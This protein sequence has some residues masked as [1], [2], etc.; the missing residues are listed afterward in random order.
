MMNYRNFEKMALLLHP[1]IDIM[2]VIIIIFI[3]QKLID[4]PNLNEINMNDILK[5]YNEIL[6]EY[7][8]HRYALVLP[9]LK[10][11][12]YIALATDIKKNGLKEL[13]DVCR[14]GGEDLISDGRNRLIC[15]KLV[16]IKSQKKHFT[17]LPENTDVLKRIQRN[18]FYKR[19][20]TA[21]SKGRLALYCILETKE[22]KP[23]MIDFIVAEK[24]KNR[25]TERITELAKSVKNQK[26]DGRKE[27]NFDLIFRTK[28]NK[29]L[30]LYAVANATTAENIKKHIIIHEIGKKNVEIREKYDGKKMKASHLYR[31]ILAD[32]TGKTYRKP[33][34]TIKKVKEKYKKKVDQQKKIL[35]EVQ[36]RIDDIVA[37]EML[38]VKP[39]EKEIIT[40]KVEPKD[41]IVTKEILK[42]KPKEKEIITAKIELKNDIVVKDWKK[43]YEMVLKEKE[44]VEK[45]LKEIKKQLIQVTEH[46]GNLLEQIRSIKILF[47]TKLNK[48]NKLNTDVIVIRD[49]NTSLSPSVKDQRDAGLKI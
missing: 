4:V 18:H 27:I 31:K 7:K 33:K 28:I 11:E 16:G 30:N 9:L 38:K 39:K 47:A 29:M 1:S 17:Y 19:Q 35:D 10:L 32:F 43:K 20:A 13:I 34:S 23:D 25:Q 41:D 2:I 42:V 37:K 15:M 21:D 6:K 49:K 40:A 45:E 48:K 8:F 14:E 44:K 12:E 22:L 3:I 24:L 5:I 26:W 36:E 46:R